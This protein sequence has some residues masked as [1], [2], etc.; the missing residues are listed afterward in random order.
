MGIVPFTNRKRVH[1]LQRPFINGS[2]VEEE[3]TEQQLQ[4]SMQSDTDCDA[5][6][7]ITVFRD[8]QQKIALW[9][10]NLCETELGDYRRQRQLEG[11]KAVLGEII[12]VGSL[13]DKMPNLGGLSRTC[14]VLG[15]TALTLPSQRILDSPEFR[16]L[17]MTSDKW[18]DIQVVPPNDLPTWLVAR[19]AEGFRILA[20]E[21]SAQSNSLVDYSFPDRIIL[22]LGNEREGVPAEILHL[23]DDCIEI[24]QFGMVRSLNV[25]VTGSIVLW[26]ARKQRLQKNKP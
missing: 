8:Y 22:V 16:S 1:Q 2:L 5:I 17:S 13:I 4:Q 21:Q 6:E 24:P 7:P 26:E 19:K 3:E 10:V 20:I 15:A 11:R 12:I 9:N 25:H 14:E 18:L 23:V